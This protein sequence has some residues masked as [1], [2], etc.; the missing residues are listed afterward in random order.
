MGSNYDHQFHSILFWL[1][2]IKWE[3]VIK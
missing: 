3:K 2:G 1:L